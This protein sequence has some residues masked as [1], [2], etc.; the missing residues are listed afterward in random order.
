MLGTMHYET[1]ECHRAPIRPIP[2]CTHLW[3]NQGLEKRQWR[4]GR[5]MDVRR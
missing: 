1:L 3:F 2:G 5:A 4:D